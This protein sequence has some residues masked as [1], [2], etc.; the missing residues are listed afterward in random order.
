MDE[1]ALHANRRFRFLR[2]VAQGLFRTLFAI[3]LEGLDRMPAGGGYVLACNHLSWADPIFLLA[4]LPAEPRM[5][6][7]GAN[8]LTLEG[9]GLVR[10]L[11]R[12]IGGGVIPVDRQHHRGDRAAVVQALKVLRAGAILGIFP[13]G[14]CGLVEGQI[15][16]LKEG[17]ASFALKTDK[18]ILVLGMSGPVELYFRRCIRIRVSQLLTPLPGESQSEL[19]QRLAQAMADA[20]PPLAPQPKHKYMTWLTHLF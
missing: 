14:K 7:I 20:L 6:Y 12:Q 1:V 9:P 15:Q 2:L 17:A 5:H 8:E 3:E 10:W 19:S 11:I 13:E 16:P 4:F 18:P